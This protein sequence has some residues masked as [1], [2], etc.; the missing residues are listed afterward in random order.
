MRSYLREP[1]E[2]ILCNERFVFKFYKFICIGHECFCWLK[3]ILFQIHAFLQNCVVG[4]FAKS[5]L[6]RLTLQKQ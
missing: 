3:R 6:N 1:V 4:Y 2:V 5:I